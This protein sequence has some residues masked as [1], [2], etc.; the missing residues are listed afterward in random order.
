VGEPY[1]FGGVAPAGALE[2]IPVGFVAPGFG[3]DDPVFAEGFVVLNQ[4]HPPS[5]A[6]TKTAPIISSGALLLGF[7]GVVAI[8]LKLFYARRAVLQIRQPIKGYHNTL[9]A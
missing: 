7:S 9:L 3:V 5:K 2:G 1:E 4:Y 6:T 8:T